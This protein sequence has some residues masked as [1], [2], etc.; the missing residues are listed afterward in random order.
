MATRLRRSITWGVPDSVYIAPVEPEEED[1]DLPQRALHD[2]THTPTA[3]YQFDHA[4]GANDVS[5]NGY[6]LSVD[7]SV[8]PGWVG[9]ARHL[10]YQY[11]TLSNAV[12]SG[13]TGAMSAYGLF[14]WEVVSVQNHVLRWDNVSLGFAELRVQADESASTGLAYRHHDGTSDISYSPTIRIPVGEWAWIGFTRDSAGTGVKLFM[15]GVMIGSTTMANPPGSHAGTGRL[16]VGHSASHSVTL[17]SLKI[18]VGTELTETQ[19]QNE[20]NLTHGLAQV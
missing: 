15:D 3:L 20:Y 10:R 17:Q 9:P 5:G 2:L 12:W 4:N 6:N 7:G 11:S 1:N 18:L 13:L 14:R 19:M 16:L 8:I